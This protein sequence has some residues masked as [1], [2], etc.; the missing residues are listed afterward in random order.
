VEERSGL[1]APDCERS[2]NR[3]ATDFGTS[4]PSRMCDPETS[5]YETATQRAYGVALTAGAAIITSA[6]LSP[7][8]CPARRWRG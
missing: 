2:A 5:R 1:G 8:H 7:N 4:S 3:I 6:V